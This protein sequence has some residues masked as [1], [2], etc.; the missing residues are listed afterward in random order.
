[1]QRRTLIWTGAGLAA[2][3]TVYAALGFL[4]APRLAR[5]AFLAHCRQEWQRACTIE[6][7]RFNP[8]QLAA[9]ARG[10]SIAD[11]DGSRMIGLDRLRVD[12]ASSSLWRRA[13]V[14]TAI[15][16]EAPFVRATQRRDG[17][18]NLAAL[19]PKP[20]PEK[21]DEPLPRLVV[22]DL[23]VTHGR[24]ELHDEQR[25]EPFQLVLTPFDFRL[26]DFSTFAEGERFRLVAGSD[27]AG[28]V[29]W[30]GSLRTGP[31]ASAGTVRLSRVP[32]KTIS[33]L[34]GEQLPLAFT[35]GTLD[36]GFGY[37][38]RLEGE[39]FRLT[40]AEGR[41]RVAGLT[42]LGRGRSVPWRVGGIDLDG[43][44]LDL[45][46]RQASVARLTVRDTDTPLWLDR[47]GVVLPGVQATG[48]TA[49]TSTTEPAAGPQG[50]TAAAAAPQAGTGWT[51]RLP[52][53]RFENLRAR[54]EDRRGAAVVPFEAVVPALTVTGAG[55]PLREPVDI[56]G[57]IESAAGGTLAV[58]GTASAQPVAAELDVTLEALDLKP[59]EPYIEAGRALDFRG[60]RVS[61]QGR[62]RYD[63]AD[64]PRFA[65]DASIRDLHTQDGRA[66][67]DF[68]SWRAVDV[69]G[70]DFGGPKQGLAI[71]EIAMRSPFLRFVIGQDGIT[72]V[73][74]VLDPEGA[75]AARRA[76]LEKR[77]VE[78]RRPSQ[79][80]RGVRRGEEQAPPAEVTPP[81]RPLLPFPARIARVRVERGSLN[82][83]DYTTLRPY[84]AAGIQDLQGTITGLSSDPAARAKVALTGRVDRYAPVAIDG[85]VNYL[86][87]R[88]YT[89]LAASFRNIELTTFTPYSG[90]F[91]GYRID[92]GKL[93]AE[94][95][96]HVEN[97]RLDAKHRIVADQLE[98]GEKV[99]SPDA[100]KLPVKLVVALLKDRHGVIDLTVPVTGTLDDP[101]FRLGPVIWK[102]VLN[103]LTKI[104]TSPF[105]LLG[106]LFGEGPDLS[107]VDFAP[108]Q[109]ALDEASR[110]KIGTLKKAL[111][112]RPGLELEIPAIAVESLDGPALANA[113][114]E[115]LLAKAAAAL[116]P[117]GGAAPEVEALRA[118]PKRWRQLLV[119][120]YTDATG[121]APEVPEP[122]APG[123]DSAAPRA[124][125]LVF[126]NDWLERELR[127]AARPDA[128]A[129]RALGRARAEA[130]RDALLGDG[131]VDA[132]RVFLTQGEG[133]AT[134]SGQ[135]RMT[136]KLQ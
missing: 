94:L 10:L 47:S 23:S 64:G 30:Q 41:I 120:A 109:A 117:R 31:F 127:V 84:F 78:A 104:V 33:D 86:A 135:P 50:T 68:L 129:V 115:A 88:S 34:L 74:D 55:W 66:H 26:Q 108:G 69:L 4:L 99:D 61:A 22:E 79:R 130:V 44:A 9:E 126:G 5:D 87:A 18:F 121:R 71:R 96:Y 122:P 16:L 8:F 76:A 123:K 75:A 113:R 14:F 7:V 3:A 2:L 131:Q 114:H 11:A 43:G 136:L 21:P 24:V 12:F 56:E 36:V 82:F 48:T 65:G 40:L 1:M 89:D 63:G 95:H 37:D 42:L 132:A 72:N 97:R 105:A 52:Q 32:A 98:L 17:T 100:T 133:S 60:G 35:D 49:A 19:K 28:Q 51:L 57:R 46:R 59:F 90:K 91:A 25:R 6:S 70:I 27:R 39:P 119:R 29:D 53:L 111:V 112:E 103:L 85:E 92:K 134:G 15:T 110:S 106:S 83:A 116:A 67:E 80:G 54:I 101:K 128:E 73:Q 62:L 107:V 38:F 58:K 102:I 118:D 13:F 77:E 124:D 125:P 45:A 81:A 93:T 20:H